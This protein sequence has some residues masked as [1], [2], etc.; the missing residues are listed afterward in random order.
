MQNSV[1]KF[2]IICLSESCL[3]A[4]ILSSVSD[5]QIPSYNFD[6]MGHPSNTKRRGVCLNYKILIASE[7]HRYISSRMYKF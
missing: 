4:E 1:F 2:D 3:N 5:S 6:R 7:S